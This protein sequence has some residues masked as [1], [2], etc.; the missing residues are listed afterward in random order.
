MVE[1]SRAPC[2]PCR[3]C[4]RWCRRAPSYNLAGKLRGAGRR[5]VRPRVGRINLTGF[6]GPGPPDTDAPGIADVGVVGLPVQVVVEHLHAAFRGRRRRRCPGSRSRSVRRVELQV[7]VPACRPPSQAPVLSSHHARRSSRPTRRC[8]LADPRPRRSGVERYSRSGHG[9]A[10][11]GHVRQRGERISPADHHQHLALRAELDE[12][13][14]AFIDRQMLS[15]ASA[16]QCAKA[17]P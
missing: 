4:R 2:R 14:S 17:K 13:V 16:H 7:A 5:A 6:F 12:H 11:A 8:C 3:T 10:A 9:N 15:C 1:N